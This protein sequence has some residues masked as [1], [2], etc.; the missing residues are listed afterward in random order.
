MASIRRPRHWKRWLIGGIVL[1]VV[2]VVGG[3]FVYFHFVEGPAP[4]PFK[5]SN[6]KS[7]AAAAPLAGTWT[8]GSGSQAGYRVEETLFGQSHTAV[9]RT[10]AVTGQLTATSTAVTDTTVTVDMTQVNS[11]SGERD[12]QFQGRIMDTAQFPTA[13]FTLTTPINFGSTP[14]PA[15]T[16][17]ETA[18]G[19]LL[20][21]GTTHTVQV[22]VSARQSGDTIQVTGSIPVTFSDYNINNPSGGPA[23]VGNAGT[24]EFLMS[25]RHT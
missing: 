10:T 23:S 24:V 19:T 4:A 22:P 13:K 20:L 25:F 2:L 9:G 16:V 5:L 12:G 6:A 1:A 15:A 14:R 17:T 18:V 7:T 21:H 11:D 8:V 3:P